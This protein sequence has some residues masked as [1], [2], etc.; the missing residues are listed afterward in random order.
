MC[1]TLSCKE[2]QKLLSS[3]HSSH[4]LRSVLPVAWLRPDIWWITEV[5]E[6]STE[7][8]S[9]EHSASRRLLADRSQIYILIF[10]HNHQR[11]GIWSSGMIL[12]L[13][14]RGREFD[15]RN[16]PRKFIL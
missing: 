4:H 1:C 16:A 11:L 13:G 15:S 12:A 3:G 6:A 7:F 9:R 5:T 2:K 10:G 14:A 8:G